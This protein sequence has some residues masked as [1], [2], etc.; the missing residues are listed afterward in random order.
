M[1]VRA[2]FSLFLFSARRAVLQTFSLDSPLQ[3]P[4]Q[5]SFCGCAEPFSYGQGR[6]PLRNCVSVALFLAFPPPFFHCCFPLTSFPFPKRTSFRAGGSTT[7]GSFVLC[8]ACFGSLS[9][10]SFSSFF[11]SRL[12]TRLLQVGFGSFFFC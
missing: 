8:A 6:G 9:R 5:S 12:L 10:V 7:F 3:Q 4:A 11:F 2:G 1:F